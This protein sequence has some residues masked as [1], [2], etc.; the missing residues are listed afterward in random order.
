MWR[1]SIFIRYDM[2]VED[3][4]LKILVSPIE[5]WAHLNNKQDPERLWH[6]KYKDQ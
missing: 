6:K 2:K 1:D 4:F 3:I 5:G